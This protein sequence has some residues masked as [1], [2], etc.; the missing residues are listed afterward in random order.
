MPAPVSTNLW[1]I[2]V[3]ET[4]QVLATNFVMRPNLNNAVNYL[5]ELRTVI[6]DE[7]IEQ[8]VIGDTVQIDLKL[9]T[10]EFIA[11]FGSQHLPNA[12]VEKVQV[13]ALIMW[14]AHFTYKKRSYVINMR[15]EPSLG[16]P[17][18]EA[19]SGRTVAE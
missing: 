5:R 17:A 18:V 12:R 13:L 1:Q 16:V 19:F 3:D 9:P 7:L 15:V 6:P 8:I 11:S 14:R 4:Q 10:E 2:A